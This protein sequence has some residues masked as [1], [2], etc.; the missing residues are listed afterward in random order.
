MGVFPVKE[1]YRRGWLEEIGFDGSMAAAV[2]DRVNLVREYV[3]RAMPRRQ[4]ALLRQRVRLGADIDQYALW[5]WQCR[6][7][8][9]AS[10]QHLGGSHSRSTIDDEWLRSLARLS[11]FDDGPLRAK[12]M[13]SDAGIPLVIEPRLPQTYL[14]G[15]VFLLPNG[16]P[17]IGMTLRYDRIDNFWFVLFH[18]LIHV[19]KHLR[20]GRI[21]HIFDD[22]D[23]MDLEL[24]EMEREA[25]SLAGDALI[26]E[27]EWEVALARYVRTEDS[28]KSFAEEQR[29]HPAIV[30][31][32]IRKEADNYVILNDLVGSGEVRKHFP[33]VRLPND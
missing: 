8:A 28:V 12:K 13:L 9:L 30:A 32:R 24:N 19:T 18:E 27:S 29:I 6:I 23:Q 5:A 15:A 1:M 4:P 2:A 21:E 10:T 3:Q 16:T 14:D 11:R 25:D 17:I 33:E 26:P 7:L 31:G 20:K 22:L